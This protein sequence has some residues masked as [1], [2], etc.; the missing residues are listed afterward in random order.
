[1]LSLLAMAAPMV[2]FANADLTNQIKTDN[3]KN[4]SDSE[5][6]K[7]DDGVF[8]S[9]GAAISYTVG[10]S[11]VP[12]TYKLTA[13]VK[14]ANVKLTVNGTDLAANGE[15]T[16]GK[17]GA[18]VIGA[19]STDGKSFK[20]GKFNLELVYD[21]DA[22]AKPLQDELSL[23]I[24]QISKLTSSDDAVQKLMNTASEYQ[25]Q[26]NEIKAGTYDGYKKYELYLGAE[27]STAIQ[28]LKENLTRLKSDVKSAADNYGA[29]DYAN[30]QIESLTQPLADA[31]KELDAATDYAKTTKGC[32]AEYKKLAE[33]I[34]NEKAAVK[35]AYDGGTAGVDFSQKKVDAAVK[36]FRTRINT[37]SGNI[38]KANKNQASYEKVTKEIEAATKAHND[39]LAELIKELPGDPDVYGNMLAEAQTKLTVQLKR[40]T[41]LQEEALNGTAGKHDNA[42]ATE[43]QNMKELEAV[44]AEVAVIQKEYVDKARTNKDAYEKASNDV[45]TLKNNLA[46]VTAYADV[47][48]DYKKEIDAINAKIKGL[49]TD[50]DNH[51]KAYDLASYDY[52]SRK[53]EIENSI[54]NLDDKAQPSRDNFD[55]KER[56]VNEVV[57][58]MREALAAAKK[59][60]EALAST[61]AKDFKIVD[62]YAATA[63]NLEKTIT[64]YEDGVKTA[65]DK[66][67]AVKY[68]ADN[69]PNFD[70]TTAAIAAYQ[71]DAES[72]LKK[73]D[74]IQK[75]LNEYNAAIKQ[76]DE[77]A[78]DKTVTTPAGVTYASEINRLKK[79]VNNSDKKNLGLQ[80]QFDN[81]KGLK[82]AAF[83]NA[84]KAIKL[85]AAIKTQAEALAASYE[86]NKAN[87]DKNQ[88]VF[89]AEQMKKQAQER[90]DAY[91]AQVKEHEGIWTRTNLGKAADD[92]NEKLKAAKDAVEKQADI[93]KAMNPATDA[94]NVIAQLTDI[95]KEL[96]AIGTTLST[97]SIEAEKAMKAYTKVKETKAAADKKV[98]EVK[99]ALNGDAKKKIKAAA[100][101]N[102]DESRTAEF[103]AVA[104]T[105]ASEITTQIA[106]ID[107]TFTDETIETA[108][109][110]SKDKDGKPVD[111]IETA[112]NKISEKIAKLKTDA[113]ASTAN[114]KAYNEMTKAV[115]DKK[116]ADKLKEAKTGIKVA[117]EGAKT[118]Y[119]NL[120]AGYETEAAAIDAAIQKAYAN[121][122][123]AVDKK[124]GILDR[125]DALVKNAGVV[126]A[127]VKDNEKQN[128]DLIKQAADIQ[129]LWNETYTKISAGDQSSIVSN[130]LKELSDVQVKLNEQTDK[131]KAFYAKGELRGENATAVGTG[132]AE[133]KA[134]IIDISK[135]QDE[136]YQEAINTDNKATDAAFQKVWEAA[137]NRYNYA[138][139]TIRDYRAVTHE[140]LKAGIEEVIEANKSI[141]QYESLLNTLKETEA[142]ALK[143]TPAKTLFDVE[144]TYQAKAADY[145]KNIDIQLNDIAQKVN[146]AADEV[147]KKAFTDGL[148]KAVEDAKRDALALVYDNKNGNSAS[149]KAAFKT[150]DATVA[151]IKKVAQDRVQFIINLDKAGGIL[152]TIETAV[153]DKVV[154]AAREDAINRDYST[155][156]KALD[157][158]I[159]REEKEMAEFKH[160]TAADDL[161][162]YKQMVETTVGAAK[163]KAAACKGTM[164]ENY[165]AIKAL[166]DNFINDNTYTNALKKSRD[167]AANLKAYE[168]LSAKIDALD[169]ALEEVARYADNYFYK[170]DADAVGTTAYK[171][172]GT[173]ARITVLY[174]QLDDDKRA[175]TVVKD[176][177]SIENDIAAIQKAI[178]LHYSDANNEEYDK[179][180]AAIQ[181]IE[182]EKD[183]ALAAYAGNEAKTDE[184]QKF[185]NK[186]CKNLLT[187]LNKLKKN[188][189]VDAK[190]HQAE[191]L[192]FEKKMA[193]AHEELT[194]LWKGSLVAETYAILDAAY[195]YALDEYNTFNENYWSECHAPVKA[196]YQEEWTELKQNLDAFKAAI[197]KD[198]TDKQVMLNEPKR[199]Y[200]INTLTD[201]LK[202]LRTE[203]N[204]AEQPYK[205]ND[206]AKKTIEAYDDMESRL[207]EVQTA[208]AE[209]KHLEVVGETRQD[210]DGNTYEVT[211]R[212]LYEEIVG[213]IESDIEDVHADIVANDKNN[214]ASVTLAGNVSDFKSRINHVNADVSELYKKAAYDETVKY[215]VKNLNTLYVNVYD[216]VYKRTDA[217]DFIESD[218]KAFKEALD[219]VRNATA[220]M[221]IY[222]SDGYTKDQVQTDIDGN[223]LDKN[224]DGTCNWVQVDYLK[225]V[226]PAVKAKVDELTKTLNDLQEQV[227]EAKYI[228]GDVTGDQQVR[229]DDY[230][231]IRLWVLDKKA[232]PETGTALFHAAD[233]NADDVIDIADVS[234]VVKIFSNMVSLMRVARASNRVAVD[235]AI[236]VSVADNAGTQRIAIRL[237]NSVAY[238]GFQMDFQLPEGMS[239]ASESMTSRADGHTLL[240]HDADGKHRVLVSS[241]ENRAFN[242]TEST[243]LYLDVTGEGNLNDLQITNIKFTD[244]DAR[245]YIL[246]DYGANQST[247]INGVNADANSL[248][249]KIYNVGGKLMNTLK[250]GVNIIRNADGSTRKVIKK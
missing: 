249:A 188:M 77:T 100:D 222:N 18:L 202:D 204:N 158:Q 148:E 52:T 208:I 44:K 40:I 151:N 235:D 128:T 120:V 247:G 46:K 95:N 243:L 145:Q 49:E 130:W 153:S 93:V 5:D 159:A 166:L 199:T 155:K 241:D 185:Y 69:K 236:E 75:A 225:E 38:R 206:A 179:L 237:K 126:A 195:K 7:V 106:L 14:D 215:D 211:Y 183:A 200:T 42:A 168:V 86:E 193:Q 74:E 169:T 207:K 216:N 194:N 217:Y 182:T 23:V 181:D 66:D 3:P 45:K 239:I 55:A 192:P 210:A 160:A 129:T 33:D 63:S 196:E 105:L 221:V 214:N 156:V 81:A 162:A 165:R 118:Y 189:P 72:T 24:N 112:L 59:A 30:K 142:A 132:L 60:V 110:D 230:D 177:A 240:S 65:Y 238:T 116:M 191:Y 36:S 26:I 213:G 20:V 150:V 144:R 242:D 187:E 149:V 32:A 173:D 212:Q 136:G 171:I 11:F 19:K 143:D 50:I 186:S 22:T 197:D 12:G 119:E 233:V 146:V 157:S 198:Q 102:E 232:Q 8:T 1:M 184:I 35:A 87:F 131:Q 90:V 47:K 15:Y 109:A 164:F 104:K 53:T 226:V 71:T 124:Q 167:D 135:R 250:K 248:K 134:T 174:V 220:N 176:S 121:D 139:Q 190:T 227:D 245:L 85:N 113:E 140:D 73:Y 107:Q 10:D 41:A 54:K 117:G 57:P 228:L 115:N 152:A 51:N 88:T 76:L 201:G 27:N 97:I 224:D 6:L 82:D 17:A 231:Q 127:N 89:A 9:T 125:I 56:V 2:A 13:G 91:K 244:A 61:E 94:A 138:V 123:N 101:Y 111:G 133:V 34:Q 170:N 31:K 96:E 64:G 141:Y 98:D 209:M 28:K 219:G 163:E 175:G 161:K 62:K 16:L 68:E 180:K 84:V 178:N 78:V 39:A 172:A 37:L 246:N 137:M 70:K 122:R 147:Y 229:V 79:L 103:A 203:I 80:N 43:A 58:K 205:D 234:G 83:T 92:I 154:E 218:K 114:W 29:Y 4:W 67:G 21:F 223:V 25:K 48:A 108:W 99:L